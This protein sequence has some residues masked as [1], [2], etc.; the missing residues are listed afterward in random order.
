MENTL[1]HIFDY[2]KAIFHRQ[3]FED[4]MASFYLEKNLDYFTIQEILLSK[5]C[6]EYYFC[7]GIFLCFFLYPEWWIINTK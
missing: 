6:T 4:D 1:T 5:S 3:K 2:E 7:K